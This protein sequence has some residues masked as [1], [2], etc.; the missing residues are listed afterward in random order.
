MSIVFTYT[1]SDTEVSI[2]LTEAS[3]LFFKKQSTVNVQNWESVSPD[4]LNAITRIELARLSET[5]DVTEL[6][7]GQGYSLTHEFVSNLTNSQAKAVGLP[8]S[9]PLQ[10]RLSFNGPFTDPQ[11]RINVTWHDKAGTKKRIKEIGSI[12]TLGEKDYRIPDTLFHVLSKASLFNETIDKSL[13]DRVIATSELK[14][15]LESLIGEEIDTDRTI[16][17]LKLFHAS[18]VSLDVQLTG[19]GVVFEPVLFSKGTVEEA[20]ARGVPVEESNQLLTPEKQNYFV[21]RFAKNNGEKGAYTISPGEYV[22]ID[23]SLRTAMGV[24]RKMQSGSKE[25]RE[26]FVRS[27][28][29]FI[30]QELIDRGVTDEEE[31]DAVVAA[32]F[33]ESDAYSARVLSVGI[34]EQPVIP[35]VQ[36]TENT[37]IPEGFGL[38][39]GDQSF[40]ISETELMLLVKDA[41][42][43]MSEGQ[44]HFE[45]ECGASLPINQDTVAALSEL[46]KYIDD[47]NLTTENLTDQEGT[48]PEENS[49]SE[50]EPEGKDRIAVIVESNYEDPTFSIQEQPRADFVGYVRPMGLCNDPKTHQVTGIEWLQESWCIGLSGVL[51]ADDMGLGKTFQ[52]LAFLSW[53]QDKRAS[54]GLPN[55]P[56]LLLAPTSLLGNWEAET[57][58]HLEAEYS[59]K[60]DLLYGSSRIKGYKKPGF[61]G[62]DVTEGCSTLDLNQLKS[63]QW[64]LTTYDTLRDYQISFSQLPIACVIFDEMQNIKNIRA[65]RTNAA[66]ALNADFKIG[67]TGTPVENSLADIWTLFDTL[68]PGLLGGLRDFMAY[69]ADEEVD[70]TEKLS[71]LN[72]KLTS[73]SL[74]NSRYMLRRMKSDVVKDLPEKREHYVKSDMPEIQAETYSEAIGLVRTASSNIDKRN[75]FSKIR[76]IS[77]HPYSPE[78]AEDGNAYAEQSARLIELFDILD[79]AFK[80]GRKALIFIETIAMHEWLSGYIKHRYNLSHYPQR[81]YGSVTAVKR[82]EIVNRFQDMNNLGF[83]V[84]LL[85]PKAAGVGLTLTAATVVIHLSRWW[86]PAVEDQCTDRAYRIGQTESVDVY[87]LMAQHPALADK[88]FDIVLNDLLASKRGLSKNTLVPVENGS[89]MEDILSQMDN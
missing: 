21:N 43:L 44:S 54:L 20:N 59:S 24:V 42:S 15:A 12:A 58:L 78:D 64:I 48:S 84:L 81:I 88:S 41:P 76:G 77:L 68:V 37:W 51:L 49:G 3:G 28:A 1:A 8:E 74:D 67:L 16:S 86:N 73:D 22:F 79:S 19:D 34:W 23:P 71:E 46:K 40:I 14:L 89:E 31:L 62:N 69:Y 60:I 87:Y 35:F 11:T 50:E 32:S 47:N 9:I 4:S 30:K 45:L 33:V 17:Q 27:P 65:M 25:Q 18:S 63:S 66:Q 80:E 26:Q 13:D 83:D 6:S 36:K 29:S 53:L 39:I 52:T 5:G 56:I 38:K 72:R 2:Y 61:K 70:C 55:K 57:K 82:M 75:A 85:S 10:L 7:N